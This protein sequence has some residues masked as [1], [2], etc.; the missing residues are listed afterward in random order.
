M[1]QHVPL[2]DQWL[3]QL[4]DSSGHIWVLTSS[5]PPALGSTVSIQAV[6]HYEPILL[7][8]EDIGEHYAEE[9]ERVNV[10]SAQ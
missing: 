9:Q 2:L 8:G 5:P 6:I 1:Q 7:G 10:D 3:Y 4:Q